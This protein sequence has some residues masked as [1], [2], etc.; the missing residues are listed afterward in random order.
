M[1]VLVDASGLAWGSFETKIYIQALIESIPSSSHD[2]SFDIIKPKGVGIFH[3]HSIK[4]KLKRGDYAL[5][6]ALGPIIVDEFDGPTLMSIPDLSAL[7]YPKEAKIRGKIFRH[8][9]K[10]CATLAKHI[11]V[12][13]SLVR[14][15]FLRFFNYPSRWIDVFPPGEWP[16]VE[17]IVDGKTAE[18]QRIGLALPEKTALCACESKSYKNWQ[19]LISAF[20]IAKEKEQLDWHLAI[21]FVDRAP[22]SL[23]SRS[24][25][26]WLRIFEVSDSGS[27]IKLYNLAKAFIYPSLY[28][29]FPYPLVSAMKRGIPSLAS[30]TSSTRELI[31]RGVLFAD[32]RNLQ[33]LQ[34]EIGRLLKD[35]ALRSEL[36]SAGTEEAGKFR[37]QHIASA[38]RDVYNKLAGVS[39]P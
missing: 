17:K 7:I 32:A 37:W 4:S 14:R 9:L 24:M 30:Q 31:N 22:Q 18:S 26:S 15:E 20:G 34:R 29:G 35:E 11:V 36:S 3:E 5:F 2:F 6:H 25:P 38:T 27:L 28:D 12:P 13:S 10:R 23:K 33:E 21:A 1:K 8:Y 16:I 39:W 19:Q